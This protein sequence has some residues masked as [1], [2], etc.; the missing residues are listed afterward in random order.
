MEI[1]SIDIYIYKFDQHYNLRGVKETPGK[2][3]HTNYFFEPYWRQVYSERL[4]SCLIKITTD[5]DCVGWGETQAP[6]IPETPASIIEKL[7]APFLIGRN[8]LE[9]EVIYDQLYHMMEVRGHGSSFLIDALA[10]LDIALWDIKG[11]HYQS[12]IY[13]LLGGPFQ[14][15]LPA[16]VSGLRQ[17][18]IAEQCK[19]A[20]EYKEHG[21]E[22]VKLFL[23]RG[24]KRDIETITAVRKA[25]GD[26]FRLQTDL[27]WK[28]SLSE[29]I[30]LGRVLDTLGIEFIESPLA[31]YDLLSHKQLAEKLDTPIAVG[32]PL[33]TI[34]EFQPWFANQAMEIVQP[35]VMRTGITAANKIANLAQANFKPI[36]LHTGVST[37]IG[38]AATWQVAASLSN[39]LIQEFQLGLFERNNQMLQTPLIEQEGLLLVPQKPG[40]GIDVNETFVRQH[41]TNH[42]TIDKNGTAF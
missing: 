10:G 13:E 5:T 1:V 12:P 9:T 4:E 3:P 26:E 20:I 30:Q 23:G 36:A 32:E 33:R 19:A 21:F 7:F 35:D 16:Y 28:Y 34:Y 8:P 27:L 18:T 31:P 38:I 2:I 17:E 29:C 37:N 6:I 22:G 24:L 11:K 40:L 41:S 42:W 15:K 39:H 25:V 14:L